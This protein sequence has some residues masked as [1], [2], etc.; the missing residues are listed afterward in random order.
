MDLFYS[1]TGRT[2]RSG[3]EDFFET[4]DILCY[5][6]D[7]FS[8]DYYTG[9]PSVDSFSYYLIKQFGEDTISNLML[10]PDTVVDVTGKEWDILK[11][12]W[13]QYIMDKYAGKEIPD[14]MSE[15]LY[16]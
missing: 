5:I 16:Y 15:Y 1:F 11:E 10:F 12:E 3:V 8:L 2:Y 6:Y 9:G 13:K 4:S 14:R 7:E